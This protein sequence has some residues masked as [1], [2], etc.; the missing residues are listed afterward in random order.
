MI[1]PP[2]AILQSRVGKRLFLLFVACALVPLGVMA[3]LS[4]SQVRDLLIDQGKTR[5]AGIAKS[6]A[7][8]VYERMLTARDMA[9]IVASQPVVSAPVPAS[10]AHQFLFLGRFDADGRVEAI[11]GNP[12]VDAEKLV[13]EYR[14]MASPPATMARWH[15]S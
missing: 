14:D 7:L 11:M 10:I 8:G 15:P 3:V 1:K 12:P 2:P 13:T 9:L 4:L 6:Y 5:L